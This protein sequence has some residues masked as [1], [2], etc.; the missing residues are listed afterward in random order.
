ML[1]HNILRVV[2][3]TT[4]VRLNLK[5]EN[6]VKVMTIYKDRSIFNLIYDSTELRD[7]NTVRYVTMVTGNVTM[8]IL[9]M[10]LWRRYLS[11]TRLY[12]Y[13]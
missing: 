10:F 7:S 9:V 1:P 13:F 2:V 3:K 12:Y 11:I 6:S 8:V 5:F 4:P